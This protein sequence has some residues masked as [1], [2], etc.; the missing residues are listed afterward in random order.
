MLTHPSFSQFKQLSLKCIVKKEVS[1]EDHW[2]ISYSTSLQSPHLGKG[3]AEKA[4]SKDYKS[5]QNRATGWI[6]LLGQ[7]G[8]APASQL[9]WEQPEIRCYWE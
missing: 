3:D 7:L 2:L 4:T 9:N 5:E 1:F 6:T 8:F